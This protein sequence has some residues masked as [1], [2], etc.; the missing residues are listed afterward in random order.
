MGYGRFGARVAMD[1]APN[2]DSADKFNPM[3]ITIADISGTGAADIMYM[4][5][6]RCT[7][8]INLSGNAL[9]DAYEISPLP[10]MEPY[11]KVAVMDFLGN[12]TACIVWSSPLP[13]HAAAPMQYIDL[14][15]GKKPYLMTSYHNGMGKSVTLTYKSSSKYYIEDKLKGDAWATRLPFPVHCVETITTADDVSQTNYKQSYTYHHGYYDHEER[16]FRG[17]GRVETVDAEVI[18]VDDLTLLDQHPVLTKTWYHTGAWIRRETLL[19]RF[20]KEYYP[21]PDSDIILPGDVSFP[22][23]LLPQ[24][25]R[26]AY[27]ALKSVPLRQEVYGIDGTDLE[28]HPYTVTAFGYCVKMVQP[29]LDNRFAS[30]YS[31]QEQSVAWHLER[32]ADDPRILHELTLDIDIYGNVLRSA[33]VSYPRNSMPM[34][35]PF[36][37]VGEQAK[38]LIAITENVFTDDI[39]SDELYYRLRVPC[40]TASYELYGS[41]P[42]V[43]SFFTVAGLKTDLISVTELDFSDTPTGTGVEK[44]L[45]S[46]TRSLYL[47]DD[48]VTVLDFGSVQALGL[49]YQQYTLAFTPGIITNGYGALVT[50]TMLTEGAYLLEDDITQ[51]DDTGCYWLPSGTMQYDGDPLGTFFV[52]VSFTDPWGNVTAI[53]YWTNG[54]DNYYLVPDTVTESYAVINN[55]STVLAYDWRCLQP[56]SMQDMNEN[57]SEILYDA[58]CMPVA[59]ALKG[60]GTEADDLDGIDPQDAGDITNQVDFWTSPAA[61]TDHL[62]Q[63]AT[64]RCVYDLDVLPTAVA[65]IAREQHYVDN[66]SSPVLIRFSYTDGFG[67]IAMHKVQAAD[68]PDTSLERWIGSGKTVYNN[69]GKVVMQYEP[70]FSGTHEYDPAEQAASA[71]VSPIMH[72]DALGR[73]ERTDLPDGSY[74]KTL[75]DAWKQSSYDNNDTV[76]D[77]AW[78]TNYSL[79]SPEE[80]DAATK[81]AA[82]DDTPTITWLDTLARP[83]YTRQYLVPPDP[84]NVAGTDYYDSYVELDI[85]SNR[86]A[87]HDARGLTPLQYIYNTL[88]AVLQQISIDSGTQYMLSDVGGQPLYSWDADHRQFHFTYDQLR[89][90]LTKE[91][92]PGTGYK[93]LEVMSYGEARPSPTVNNFRGKLYDVYDGAGYQY[94]KGYDFKG[95]PADTLRYFTDDYTAHPDWG[96]TVAL[97]AGS[98]TTRVFVDAL[99][100]PVRIVTPDTAHTNYTYEK[101]GALYNVSVDGVHGLT[102]D[103]VNT[104][105]YDAHGRRTKVQYENGV[106]TTYEYDPH[107]FRVTRIRTTR[108]SDSLVL[109]DLKYWYDP[110]GN[111][112]LQ[113]D[114]S[115]DSVSGNQ[116]AYFDTYSVIDPSNDYTYDALYRLITAVGREHAGDD[117]SAGYD[118]SMRMQQP[119][120]ND[121]SAIR[122]Y[123][124]H[125]TY[126]Q[127]GNMLQMQHVTSGSGSWTRDFTIDSAS[128]RLQDAD[129]FYSPMITETYT[130]DNRGNLIDGMSHLVS[131]AY[132]ELNRLEK[133]EV[134]ATITSYYQYDAGGERIRKVTYDSSTT[135]IKMRKYLG[136]WELYTNSLAGDDTE[137]LHVMDDAARVAIIDSDIYNSTQTQ[138]YQFSNHLGTATLEMDDKANVI[139][140]EEY[141]PFGSTSFQCGPDAITVSLKRYRYTGKERDEETGLYYHGAR[142]Y[143]PWLVRWCAVDPMESKLSPE[144]SYCYGHD[145]PIKWNDLTGMEPGDNTALESNLVYRSSHSSP[146]TGPT[147]NINA[148]IKGNSVLKEEV[149]QYES[150]NNGAKIT[151]YTGNRDLFTESKD[152]FENGH[153][154]RTAIDPN[155]GAEAHTSILFKLKGSDEWLTGKDLTQ[156]KVSQ[157]AEARITMV[158]DPKLKDYEL[159]ERFTHETTHADF[160]A[161]MTRQ[162]LTNQITLQEYNKQI[163]TLA[164]E[165]STTGGY[166]QLEAHKDIGN[167]TGMFN[168]LASSFIDFFKSTTLFMEEKYVRASGGAIDIRENG[169]SGYDASNTF[170]LVGN[171]YNK[172][173]AELNSDISHYSKASSAPAFEKNIIFGDNRKAFRIVD[174]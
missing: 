91:V 155:V 92:D 69:K 72:Y 94:L 112:T 156:N 173:V 136:T 120:P 140:Y 150:N 53:T 124:Q 52:P 15:G 106:T 90:T 107:T 78:Y 76:L 13:Q 50:G 115:W 116:V 158:F 75:W 111:I 29:L 70:Y 10:G 45:L 63:H 32:N 146:S 20:A 60:K 169:N 118:D 65:M 73:V 47:N 31:Y 149:N 40:E 16:E 46:K 27:R 171:F 1:N 145:N 87:V 62:L 79:G 88:K 95:N 43:G 128:N 97:E 167:K 25:Q 121:A 130:Y 28:S 163:T 127:V 8:W 82:H 100:R 67:R 117:F 3:Y 159:L 23:G 102:S 21:T 7:A 104:V 131:M 71:G 172:F 125:Y 142:Y 2:F 135:A 56:S 80:V 109:Q 138:R 48:T 6:N 38:T 59:M 11:S 161:S 160:L 170:E 113:H 168:K 134:T 57:I 144:S 114:D 157:I 36:V 122:S 18:I 108:N 55:V 137:T 151:F 154:V 93:V 19:S 129:V 54:T 44:R 30:F 42:L 24:E 37:V 103:I 49:P 81:A 77:S 162:L 35:T 64:W 34:D 147:Y 68:D 132:N 123:T 143:A 164:N 9:S 51:F 153:P 26:E 96:G 119:H 165:R 22:F 99:S 85:L 133:V 66:P 152:K 39:L 84:G 110:V 98:H 33:K 86:I 126:D 148:L 101:S 166:D 174:H 105:E 89:R 17:F 4:G 141:Y 139:S 14:M 83:F 61:H 74:T 58:L 5:N 41:V 12:G